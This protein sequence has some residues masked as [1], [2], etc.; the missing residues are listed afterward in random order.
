M[1]IPFS[2]LLILCLSPCLPAGEQEDSLRTPRENRTKI[3]EQTLTITIQKNKWEHSGISPDSPVSVIF[4]N[5]GKD[6]VYLHDLFETTAGPG[7]P[8]GFDMEIRDD[9]N[10][11]ILFYSTLVKIELSGPRKYIALEPGESCDVTLPLPKI[12]EEYAPLKKLPKGAYTMTVTYRNNLGRRC[13]HG[14]LVSKPVSF[15]VG[16]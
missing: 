5:Q 10:R 16:G 6:P 13:F 9:Q 14:T 3:I 8:I 2:A 15:T 12:I 4:R 1:K 7:V 11:H